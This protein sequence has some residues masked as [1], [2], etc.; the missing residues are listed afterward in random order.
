M[1]G[2]VRD[3]TLV[4]PCADSGPRVDACLLRLLAWVD[5][6][7]ENS[8]E[9]VW[10]DDASTDGSLER[11]RDWAARRPEVRV[12]ALPRRFGWGAALRVGVV[13]SRGR[14]VVHLDVGLPVG[15]WA[16]PAL[17]SAVDGGAEVAVARRTGPGSRGAGHEDRRRRTCERTCLALSRLLLG[18]GGSALL[19]GCSAYPRETARWLF[20]RTRSWGWGIRAEVLR[21][22]ALQGCVVREVPV[23]REEGEPPR[24]DFPGDLRF[25]VRGSR[26]CPL[27]PRDAAGGHRSLARVPR[28]HGP[29]PESS[30]ARTRALAGGLRAAGRRPEPVGPVSGGARGRGRRA[31][32]RG[33][34][35]A[36]LPRRPRH[37]TH[38]RS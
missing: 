21:M 4:V 29:R 24:L 15:P 28:S 22:A 20:A 7:G 14:R 18:V 38:R 30:A 10:V 35:P 9:V 3:L 6:C 19:G 13:D 33:P 26:E 1:S 36:R 17:L 25:A 34:T 12:I 2:S 16:I 8:V 31:R 27:E 32:G 11:A 37:P 23:P 5:E